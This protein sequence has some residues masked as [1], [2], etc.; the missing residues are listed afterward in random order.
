MSCRTLF[1][2]MYY[3]LFIHGVMHPD[4]GVSGLKSPAGWITRRALGTRW[5]HNSSLDPRYTGAQECRT[6]PL[7]YLPNFHSISLFPI[8]IPLI[9][10]TRESFVKIPGQRATIAS[11]D[12]AVD[13]VR[14]H[15]QTE[16]RVCQVR[17]PNLTATYWTVVLGPLGNQ[18]CHHARLLV[19]DH[20]RFPYI[21]MWL[22]TPI[23]SQ[24]SS[25]GIFFFRSFPIL[26]IK[27]E[28]RSYS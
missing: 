14:F 17:D 15:W 20:W 10:L 5:M 4:S 25:L 22:V 28:M 26:Q 2:I 23:S 24:I 13:P 9:L 6:Y 16:A 7:H 21:S 1:R 18:T 19:T 27:T 12:L 8:P 3:I 11:M